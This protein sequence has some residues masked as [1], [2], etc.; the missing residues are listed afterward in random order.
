MHRL[1]CVYSS[2]FF[3]SEFREWVDFSE[4]FAKFSLRCGGIKIKWNLGG[5]SVYSFKNLS[6][7]KLVEDSV[8]AKQIKTFNFGQ[9]LEH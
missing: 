9:S 4:L 5:C 8:R 6:L 2:V 3:L 1:I 7:V